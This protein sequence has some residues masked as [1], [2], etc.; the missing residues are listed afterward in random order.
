MCCILTRRRM[1]V[2]WLS[3]FPR[4]SLVGVSTALLL[5]GVVR[6]RRMALILLRCSFERLEAVPD[7]RPRFMLD[8]TVAVESLDHHLIWTILR[9][10]HFRTLLS[11][12]SVLPSNGSNLRASRNQCISTL[13]VPT[14]EMLGATILP[15]VFGG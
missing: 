8:D 3:L 11:F 1:S 14:S 13:R 2:R 9:N 4:V 15:S 12:P 7:H 6:L 5:R 10:F